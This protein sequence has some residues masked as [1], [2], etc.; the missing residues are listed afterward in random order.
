MRATVLLVS[1]ALGVLGPSAESQAQGPSFAEAKRQLSA[2]DA[3]TV[4]AGIEGLGLYGRPRAVQPLAER[5]RQGLP[6]ELLDAALDTLMVLGHASAGPVLFE[7]AAHR[8]PPVRAKA[9]AAIVSC[10]PRGAERALAEALSDV[11]A[12]VRG[13]AALGLGQLDAT[14]QADRLFFAL[15]RGVLEA[16]PALGR[17]AKG[18]QVER[19]LTF[20]GEI[21]FDTLSPAL[22]EVLTRDDV[23]RS[24]K[25]GVI[26]RLQ[27]L[28][29]AEVKAF[30][31][32]FLASL[33]PSTRGRDPIRRAAEDAIL[34]IAQ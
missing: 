7:L 4:R 26:A 9:I 31:Q 21:P 16:A 11:D 3:E 23:S 29:T 19:L 34:R 14:E 25:L 24:A 32:D 33:P 10:R 30:L 20:L 13:A 22:A 1:A 15:E 8:R 5:I 6:P 17:I 28:A 2:R 18:D 12:R 27:E